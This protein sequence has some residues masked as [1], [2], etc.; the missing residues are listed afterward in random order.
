MI[1]LDVWG[2][3]SL[4]LSCGLDREG[5]GFGWELVVF[6][7]FGVVFEKGVDGFVIV[8]LLWFMYGLYEV[9]VFVVVGL[10]FF[11]GYVLFS[12]I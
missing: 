4:V 8:F 6:V 11:G 2:S 9:F 3:G 7:C 1:L 10:F 5:E 12:F